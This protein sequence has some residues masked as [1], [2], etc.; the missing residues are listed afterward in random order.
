M[1]RR[2]RQRPRLPPAGH[3]AKDE[4]GILRK[5]T[6]AKPEPLHHPRPHA[7]DQRIGAQDQGAGG[8]GALGRL[9]VKLQHI[10]A[11]LEHVI[12]KAQHMRRGAGAGDADDISAHV[13]HQ[14]CGERGGAKPRDFDDAQPGKRA[15]GRGHGGSF[16]GKQAGGF[17]PPDPRRVFE[18]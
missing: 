1:P 6:G 4:A 9:Q 5:I 12:G 13:G 10:A 3:A 11:T 17:A 7:L 2:L 8:G 16:P 15:L 18:Q 14:H